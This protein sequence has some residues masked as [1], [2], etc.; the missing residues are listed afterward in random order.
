MAGLGH[1]RVDEARMH[2]VH[3]DLVRRVLD[4][5]GLG[6][7]P[8]CTL[9][10][11]IGR[12][13]VR[14]DDAADGRDVDDRAAAGTLHGRYCGLGAEED[15]R[16][17]DLHD[18]VPLLER[19]LGQPRPGG[20]ARLNV[21][22]RIAA[23]DAGDVAQ[24]V[25][26]AEGLL[27]L[28]R[29]SRPIAPRRRRLERRRWLCRRCR[30]SRSRRSC[31]SAALL[32]VSSTLAPCRANTR[33]VSAPMPD[34]PPVTMATLPTSLFPGCMTSSPIRHSLGSARVALPLSRSARS[35]RSPS[36]RRRRRSRDSAPCRRHRA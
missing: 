32:S 33:A 26:P 9:R 18:A 29:R 30:L 36:P 17:V 21:Q 12:V 2:R 22:L 35:P 16:R 27:G 15:A 13:G 34:A 8:H 1:R 31:P 25:E 19:L 24:D 20:E 23:G 6:E 4:R 11:V 3:A 7:D 5:G 28:R 14:A 10:G